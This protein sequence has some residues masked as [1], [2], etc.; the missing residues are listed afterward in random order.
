MENIYTFKNNKKLRYG[1]TTG[2][3][4]A[5]ASKAAA[6]MLFRKCEIRKISIMTPKGIPLDL[7]VHDIK[8]E[9]DYVSCAIQ[10]DSGDDPDVTDGAFVYSKVCKISKPEIEID[11]GIG[12]GR[13]TKPGLEQ[14]IG[15]AAINRVPREMIKHEIEEICSEFDYYGGIR[16]EISIPKG[17]EL[18]KRTFNPRLGIEGGISVLGTS[19]IVEP[20]SEEALVESIKIEMRMLKAWGCE[21]MLVT[22]G[23][24]GENFTS[25]ELSVNIQNGIKCSNFIGET[26]DYAVELELKSLMFI[27]HI[28]KL[29]KVAGGIMNTHSRNADSRMEI[30]A[31]SALR[32]GISVKGAGKI[33]DCITT[34]EAI[35]ILIEE[36]IQRETMDLLAEKIQ[37]YMKKRAYD[38]LEIEVIVFSNEYGLLSKT[39]RADEL[40]AKIDA[41]QIRK[42]R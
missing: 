42:D 18:A 36:K 11:G 21:H 28:G 3:C 40:L 6:I 38:R 4:A 19:G 24:Y 14:P 31:A 39:R 13:V 22:L 17:V 9:E 26:I 41:A 32:A 2:S 25:K 35:A 5:A 10:K 1:Y 33:L 7:E 20:M 23:N 29:V 34:D 8:I 16:V 37:F 27:G 30:M 12:V 15:N